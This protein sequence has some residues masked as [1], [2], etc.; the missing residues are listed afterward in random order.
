MTNDSTPK[1]PNLTAGEINLHQIDDKIFKATM[2][3]KDAVTLFLAKFIPEEV[4]QHIDLESLELDNT[5][6]V[7]GQLKKLQSD[8]VWKGKFK[9]QD[10]HL[11]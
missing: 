7:T 1:N 11:I 6:Y 2:Q 9:D 10:L 8:V 4:R 5:E 3:N